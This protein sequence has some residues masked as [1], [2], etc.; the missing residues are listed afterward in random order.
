MFTCPVTSRGVSASV[1][2][3]TSLLIGAR[4]WSVA[5]IPWERLGAAARIRTA[6]V[7]VLILQWEGDAATSAVTCFLASTQ[8]WGGERHRVNQSDTRR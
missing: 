3:S 1:Q 4:V 2:A 7:L 8:A 6:S 5:A